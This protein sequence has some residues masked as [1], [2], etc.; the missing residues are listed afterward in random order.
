MT[1][2]YLHDGSVP[3]LKSLLWPELLDNLQFNAQ[4]SYYDLQNLGLPM[5]FDKNAEMEL[6]KRGVELRK[7]NGK[8]HNTFTSS[9]S[10]E[11]K[12]SVFE[13]FKVL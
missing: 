3:N 2:P 8:A 1:A 6:N 4:G 5:A 13:Y 11:E 9:L 12:N 7:G 10:E